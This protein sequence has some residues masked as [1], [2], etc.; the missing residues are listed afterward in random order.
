MEMKFKKMFLFTISF[1]VISSFVLSGCTSNDTQESKENSS[2]DE[3]LTIGFSV[4]ALDIGLRTRLEQSM[5]ET[6]KEKG[7][8]LKVLDNENDT[9]KAISQLQNLK[10]QNVDSII[11]L[12]GSS[13]ALNDTIDSI[14]NDGI[15]VIG[16]NARVSAEKLVSYI[17]S[18][19][20]EGGKNVAEQMVN[21]L[22][23]KY[24]EA[25]GN[26][27]IMNGEVGV[28]AEIERTEGI[29]SVLDKHENINVLVEKEADWDRAKGLN[30]MQDWIQKYG[31]EIDGVIA[32][33]DQMALGAQKALQEKNI[34]DV[35]VVGIDGEADAIKAVEEGKQY[36]TILQNGEE[37]GKKALE[38]AIEAAKGNDVDELYDIPFETITKDNV[39]EYK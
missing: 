18:P 33:N 24:G 35:P 10:T 5:Q 15:P 31:D 19:D 16:V 8:K 30:L 34:D 1:L 25:K 23:E 3:Q 17:G 38:I 27:V 22:E 28:S 9:S 12:S 14:V 4:W 39:A 11:V 7:V 29:Y 20:V 6:A 2:D 32:Q 21:A 37:Q 13:T 36:A 26:I